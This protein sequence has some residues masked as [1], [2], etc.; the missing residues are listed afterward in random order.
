MKRVFVDLEKCTR[1]GMCV[2]RCPFGALR[3]GQD[4]L[5]FAPGKCMP[6]CEICRL[7][8]PENAIAYAEV[9]CSNC[10]NGCCG[11]CSRQNSCQGCNGCGRK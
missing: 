7:V 9:S 8:C 1:C 11:K 3:M 10:Q 4:A 6:E 5:L 2:W